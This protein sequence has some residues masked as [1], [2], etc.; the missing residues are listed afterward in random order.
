MIDF[1]KIKETF[2]KERVLSW[3]NLLIMTITFL[4]LG[5][6]LTTVFI[7][8]STLQYLEQQTQVT[9]F[10]RDD[11]AETSILDLKTQLEQDERIAKATYVSKQEALKIFADIHE[12]EPLLLEGVSANTLPASLKVQTNR[13][14]DLQF[15][16][17]E[18]SANPGVEGVKFFEDVVSQFQKIAGIIYIA[19]FSLTA[20]FLFVSYSAV[21]I[22]LRTYIN[23]KGTELE[24]LK[25]VGASNEYVQRPIISQGL[26][27]S[28]ASSF[29]LRLS[30]LWAL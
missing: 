28:F 23:R 14:S 18:L 9:A 6:F 2:Q 24:I 16:A 29:W 19:G 5:V 10:F 7:T 13:V 17:E 8:Q 26:F 4:V 20:V 27:F 30:Y 1:A 21:V 11:F 12:D 25:L 22:T 3:S 15:I